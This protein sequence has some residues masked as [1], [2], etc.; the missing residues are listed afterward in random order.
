M[1]PVQGLYIIL[2]LLYLHFLGL[3]DCRSHNCFESRVV[4]DPGLCGVRDVAS[5]I[6]S[7]D[8]TQ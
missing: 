5:A 7:H 3:W 4:L 2:V 6:I 1:V 8:Q